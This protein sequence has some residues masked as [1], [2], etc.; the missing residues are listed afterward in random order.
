[1]ATLQVDVR[2][3]KL[4]A[5]LEEQGTRFESVPLVVGDF[6]IVFEGRPLFVWERK[7]SADM[8]QSIKDSRYKEQKER[9]LRAYPRSRVMYIVEGHWDY[10]AEMVKG[11]VINTMLRDDIKVFVVPSVKST[12]CFIA[13][14]MVRIN[15]DPAKYAGAAPQDAGDY[16]DAL[17]A[18][19]KK[20]DMMDQYTFS[21]MT[22]SLIPGVSKTT[23]KAVVDA[24]GTIPMFCASSTDLASL[25]ALKLASGRCLGPKLASKVLSFLKPA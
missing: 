12:A 3:T 5:L 1:M 17:A 16:V 24:F 20:R 9:L 21:V 8:I 2:E 18:P 6:Q 11:A 13:D 15:R 25:A 23:A 19:S 7:T 10:S 14:V 4:A 22:L